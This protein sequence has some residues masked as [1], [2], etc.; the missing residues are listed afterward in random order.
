VVVVPPP[1]FGVVCV[2]LPPEPPMFGQSPLEWLLPVAAKLYPAIGW[3]DELDAEP[4]PF[5]ANA[6]P[7]HTTA[8]VRTARTASHL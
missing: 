6:I 2:P 5:A 8:A 7:A 1:P 3:P 4:D